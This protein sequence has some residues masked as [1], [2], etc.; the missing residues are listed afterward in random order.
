M[1]VPFFCLPVWWSI[2]RVLDR[3]LVGSRISPI[4]VVTGSILS[5]GCIALLIALLSAS[6]I[7]QRDLTPFMGGLVLWSVAFGIFPGSWLL[8]R[9]RTA[10]ADE[11]GR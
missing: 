10:K 7:D 5:I 11:L 1:T 4:A 6:A 8:G 2:G 9:R 3:F